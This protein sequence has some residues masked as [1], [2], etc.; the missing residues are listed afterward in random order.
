MA[1]DA[2]LGS[3]TLAGLEALG[4]VR[5]AMYLPDLGLMVVSDLHLEKG[6]ANARRGRM[7]PPYDTAATLALLERSIA[8]FEPDIVVSL[9]DSF[10]DRVG[11][12]H[13]LPLFRDHLSALMRGRDWVWV[14]GN[15]DPEPPRGLGGVS[16]AEIAVG[17][18][19]FRHEPSRKAAPGEVAGHLHP[20]ARIVQRGRSVRRRC[21]ATDGDRLVMP[22]YGAY[23]GALS[24][25]DR[26]FA[27]L[28]REETLVAFM[29]GAERLYPV[30]HARLA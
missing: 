19:L 21:F 1:G 6:A 29:L 23:T 9:G 3:F 12:E 13:M 14:S 25:L 11:S 22:A 10:D 20:G 2:G 7:V 16:A 30:P 27:G 18:L 15:H 5:G 17:P 8:L 28:F 26:A 24:L 4:D